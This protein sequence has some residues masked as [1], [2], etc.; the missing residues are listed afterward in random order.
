MYRDKKDYRSYIISKLVSNQIESFKRL[1][2]EDLKRQS[3]YYEFL[4]SYISNDKNVSI[5]EIGCGFGP[6]I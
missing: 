6:F 3:E 1:E 4:K 2:L 5:L